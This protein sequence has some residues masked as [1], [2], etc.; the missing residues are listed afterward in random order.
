M[1]KYNIIAQNITWGFTTDASGNASVQT[2]PISGA[3]RRVSLIEG[4]VSSNDWAITVKDSDGF[5]IYDNASIT[6]NLSTTMAFAT[7]TPW[8]VTTP[9]LMNVSNGGNAKAG[10]VKVYWTTV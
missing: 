3:L 2:D 9:L 7:A 6:A 5:V 4:T 10:T 8:V 1:A